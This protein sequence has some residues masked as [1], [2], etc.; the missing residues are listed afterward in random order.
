MERRML[1]ST[2]QTIQRLHK[3]GRDHIWAYYTRNMVR[4]LALTRRPV[5]VVVGNPPWLNYR[6]TV[7]VL[8]TALE[9]Q[10]KGVYGIWAGRQYATHQDVAGLFFARAAHLYLE[11]G[12]VIGMVM[13]HSALQA[14]QYSKWRTGN[15]IAGSGQ[16][17]IGV[18]FKFKRPWDLEQL[19]PND[20]F[21]VPASVVFARRLDEA[22]KARPLSGEI[23]KWEG[24]SG[25][26]DVRRVAGSLRHVP[27]GSG[28][29]YESR[30][31]QG[32][33]IVPR[34]LF[35]VQEV[36]NPTIVPAGQTITVIPRKGR[37]DKNPWKGLD[38]SVLTDQTV[39][40]AHLFDV[41]LGETV[42]PYATLEPL[43]ALLPF[44]RGDAWLPIDS[45]A[46]GR[47]DPGKLGSRMR[48]RWH[49][50][51]NLW[52]TNKASATQLDLLGQLDYMGKLSS[53]LEW[54]A[55]R[56][57][58]SVRVVYSSAG[59]PT[60]AVLTDAATLVESKLF[61]ISCQGQD[62][63]NYLLAIINSDVLYQAV[64]PFMSKGQFGARDL[65]KHLWE[66]PI[67]AFDK[68]KQLHRDLSDAGAVARKRVEGILEVLRREKDNV[69]V[70]AARKEIRTWLRESE[71]GQR[72]ANLVAKLLG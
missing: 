55:G 57:R 50:I 69:T 31:R 10:S 72:V 27:E 42:V 23:E 29:P 36:E 13:P 28:S 4:P 40:A 5:A 63:A 15:W 71:E 52:N 39:E 37:L 25:T 18:D 7:D 49:T 41:H 58:Q 43:K 65:Q 46:V 21:P 47:I 67:P 26:S 61:W 54:L 60:A 59:V 44:K 53:Q 2:V 11:D 19:Q 9:R 68:S 1:K 33:S 48:E 38:L 32:A 56:S 8:R 51:N 20:F 62:E 14:G 64:T 6:N 30:A 24:R 70:T 66:L 34:R 12:G 17:T 35:F 45:G 3:E 16:R 22:T